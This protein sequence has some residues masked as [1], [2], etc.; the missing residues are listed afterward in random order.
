MSE[1]MMMEKLRQ[2]LQPPVTIETVM[3][4]MKEQSQKEIEAMNP[5]QMTHNNQIPY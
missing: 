5:P 3:K 1:Q 4:A 2:A